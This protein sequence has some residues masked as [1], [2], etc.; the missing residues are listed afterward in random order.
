M[1]FYNGRSWIKLRGRGGGPKKDRFHW[2]VA[3]L[4]K[5]TDLSVVPRRLHV[6]TFGEN[7]GRT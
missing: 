1:A 7:T 2:A 3:P 4:L 6:L 5:R